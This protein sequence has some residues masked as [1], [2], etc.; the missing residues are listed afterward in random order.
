MKPSETELIYKQACLSKR[1]VPQVEEGRMWHKVLASCEAV[2]VRTAIDVWWAS[3]ERDAQGE[4]RSRFLPT[5]AELLGLSHYAAQKRVQRSS[6]KTYLVAWRCPTCKGGCCGFLAQGADTFRTCRR[7]IGG[8]EQNRLVFC[9]A[10]LE[11][12][13]DERESAA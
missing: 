10:A 1:I 4:L 5:P 11:V 3:I 2:D 12:V 7:P 6:Q 13:R 9:G 8:D